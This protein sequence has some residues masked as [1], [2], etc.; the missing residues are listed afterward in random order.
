MTISFPSAPLMVA[1]GRRQLEF[2]SN[3][4]LNSITLLL[5]VGRIISSFLTSR[6]SSQG[7][8]DSS[9]HSCL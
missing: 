1:N 5:C 4:P 8:Q 9:H 6:E 3:V 7:I 2:V